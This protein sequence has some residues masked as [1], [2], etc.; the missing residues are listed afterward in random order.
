M[1]NMIELNVVDI[2]DGFEI[3]VFMTDQEIFPDDKGEYVVEPNKQL[4]IV[5]VTQNGTELYTFVNDHRNTNELLKT[6]TVLDEIN[7]DYGR[8]G[9]AIPFQ[10]EPYRK[11]TSDNK[12]K[13]THM[14][15]IT[16]NQNMLLENDKMH[17]RMCVL[18]DLKPRCIFDSF[19]VT[20]TPISETDVPY[21]MFH[22]YRY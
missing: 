8:T 6:K 18:I 5:V 17:I 14:K 15:D 22:D 21:Q 19:F 3:K 20:R 16:L 1:R 12:R 7:N 2:V 4:K 11:G 10:F 9:D 13:W